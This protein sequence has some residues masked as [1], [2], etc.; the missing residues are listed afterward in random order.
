MHVGPLSLIANLF[1]RVFCVYNVGVYPV[2]INRMITLSLHTLRLTDYKKV[3]RALEP[4]K[5]ID[6]IYQMITFTVITLKGIH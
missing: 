3:Q 5:K 2:Y 6:G 4:L 1:R